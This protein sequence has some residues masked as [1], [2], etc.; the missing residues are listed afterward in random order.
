MKIID[1]IYNQP[2][3]LQKILNTEGTIA[4][5]LIKL[6]QQKQIKKIYFTGSGTSFHASTLISMYF[7][8][9]TTLDT[10]AVIPDNFTN[11]FVPSLYFKPDET[12]LIGISQS[13]TSS[14]TLDAIRKA[15]SLNFNTIAIS[16][17]T[18]SKIAQEADNVIYLNTGDE[19]IPVETRGYT[20]T[21]MLG[22]I[23]ALRLGL[24]QNKLN[25]AK[26]Q[27]FLTQTKED[28]TKLPTTL[29]TAEKFYQQHKNELVTMRKGAIAGYGY[30]YATAME[31]YLKLYETF[32]APL[33]VHEFGE[34]I[35]GYE[36]AFD[37][38]QYIFLIIAN[39]PE[40][41]LANKYI[42]FLKQITKHIFII[43]DQNIA[44]DSGAKILK[45]PSLHN[46]ELSPFNLIIPF[47]II[48][49]RN[50]EAI[51]YDTSKYPLK[52]HSFAHF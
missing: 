1:N 48:A 25:E 10:Q 47:Q 27:D 34:L 45:V 20:S 26:Y 31:A 42:E 13:G 37:A 33:S 19:G 38:D 8:K 9:F 49:S 4:N 7:N 16:E 41:S 30:N 2:E 43:T 52:A 12:L 46:D 21:I 11:Y 14:S 51:G 15:K 36:M 28:I 32:H 44:F 50:C 22:L 24:A 29:N 35:H 39:G 3:R 5:S 6:V 18:K 23:L 17:E 40:K